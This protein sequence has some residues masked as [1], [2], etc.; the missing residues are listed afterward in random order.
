MRWLSRFRKPKPIP[1]DVTVEG[2][3]GKTILRLT[4]NGEVF[5]VLML[6]QVTR[7][8]LDGTSAEFVELSHF[9]EARRFKP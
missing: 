9:I 6:M 4:H 7:S 2:Q 3:P 5:A 1:Y 8:R